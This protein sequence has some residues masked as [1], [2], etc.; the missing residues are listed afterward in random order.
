MPLR[1]NKSAGRAVTAWDRLLAHATGQLPAPFDPA[2]L[3]VL[4]EPVRRYFEAAIPAGTPSAPGAEIWMRGRIR[5][6]RWL[7][8]RAH[9]LLVPHAGT[10]WQARVAEVITGSDR[11]V[12]GEGGMDWKLLGLKRLVHA[13][14]PDVTRSAAGRVAGESIWVPTAVLPGLAATW[15]ARA[16]DRIR[17]ALDVDGQPIEVEHTIDAAGNIVAST[18][19]RW[20]DPGE[21]GT[22]GLHHFGVEVTDTASIGG[23]TIPVAGV[24]GWHHGTD[25]WEEGAFFEFRLDR[26][27]L[28]S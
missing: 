18:L 16:E 26:Y 1:T 7:P 10:V 28:L 4:D 14:G 24:A 15:E 11:Y 27:R 8:F 25:R 22:C 5:L 20:G 13:A 6:G 17:L 12:D 2:D 23:V 9:Q 19:L 3:S 21:T